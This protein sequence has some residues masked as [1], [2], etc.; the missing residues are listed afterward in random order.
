MS[1]IPTN[2]LFTFAD[3]DSYNLIAMTGDTRM[4]ETIAGGEEST[5]SVEGIV[6]LWDEEYVVT[7][8]QI[9][10]L[11]VVQRF[12]PTEFAGLAMGNAMDYS[13]VIRVMV[14]PRF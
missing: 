5:I 11:R 3:D 10:A 7:D 14:S 1:H 6:L 2:A 8:I 13:V 9:N 4:L 12:E